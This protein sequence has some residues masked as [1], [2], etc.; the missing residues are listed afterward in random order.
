MAI[1]I[2][3]HK[4]IIISEYEFGG[5]FIKCFWKFYLY[6][7]VYKKVYQL[8]MSI[9]QKCKLIKIYNRDLLLTAVRRKEIIYKIII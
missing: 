8:K 5:N 2:Q 3:H 9:I 4:E 1:N 6:H 7:P